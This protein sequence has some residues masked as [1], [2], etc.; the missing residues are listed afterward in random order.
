[1]PST[2]GPCGL[3]HTVSGKRA[4][5]TR[6]VIV[7]QMCIVFFPTFLAKL[8]LACFGLAQ[9]AE[10]VTYGPHALTKPVE[11]RHEKRRKRRSGRK[12]SGRKGG[13][14]RTGVGM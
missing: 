2:A 11:R 12:E 7:S 13:G 14:A 8:S 1:M 4:D 10:W 5:P 3:W 9:G 6:T